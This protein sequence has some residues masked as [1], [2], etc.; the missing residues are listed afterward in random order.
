MKPTSY[1]KIKTV[2]VLP[3][4]RLFVT[5]STGIQKTYDCTP[6][7]SQAPFTPLKNPHLFN[8]VQV[9][10]NGY[11]IAWN[12]DIDLSE[13]ELWLHG[14]PETKKGVSVDI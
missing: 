7:L 2:D 3:E 9:D 5:F 13:S 10:A 12:D 11:G 14:F 8:E 1:P 6:L 4:R